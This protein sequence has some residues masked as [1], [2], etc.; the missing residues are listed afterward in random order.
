MDSVCNELVP[1]GF[2]QFLMLFHRPWPIFGAKPYEANLG[3]HR[4]SI[5]T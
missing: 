1:K 2:K 3:K 4:I 5:L